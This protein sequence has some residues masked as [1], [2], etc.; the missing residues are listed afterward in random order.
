MER[1]FKKESNF[2]NSFELLSVEQLNPIF[3][4]NN[5]SGSSYIIN[6]P[7]FD[8]KSY[9]ISSRSFIL[10]IRLTIL[11]ILIY[12]T[13]ID[14]LINCNATK[15]HNLTNEIFTSEK[16]YNDSTITWIPKFFFL[17][18]IK[19]MIRFSNSMD[20]FQVFLTI[21]YCLYSIY[22]TSSKSYNEQERLVFINHI[23]L[24]DAIFVY[25]YYQ[26]VFIW[27]YFSEE[28]QKKNLIQNKCFFD[29]IEY[30]EAIE[31]NSKIISL[32]TID[33]IITKNFISDNNIVYKIKMYFIIMLLPLFYNLLMFL[34]FMTYHGDDF[35]HDRN[36]QSKLALRTTTIFRIFENSGS[37][38]TLCMTFL[39]G[40]VSNVIAQLIRQLKDDLL[41]LLIQWWNGFGICPKIIQIVV[42]L[43]FFIQ[44][45]SLIFDDI[46][47]QG[48]GA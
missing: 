44:M 45:L 14:F 16:D 20:D 9:Y 43:I 11:S 10:K 4:Y 1:V 7:D 24:C 22:Q 31:N 41:N 39:L 40:F 25:S 8:E 32:Q 12:I 28:W 46:K 6:I 35:V 34:K 27:F 3:K 2:K 26:F 18:F 42:F 47:T 38:F 5:Q 48:V 21:L 15:Y 19:L 23:L 36:M 29:W 17:N 33:A 30:S 13:L 37:F